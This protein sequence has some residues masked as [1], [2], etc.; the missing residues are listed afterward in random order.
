MVLRCLHAL[1]N[2]LL[3]AARKLACE[4]AGCG[5]LSADLAAD[6]RRDKDA[7]RLFVHVAIPYPRNKTNAC[8][9]NK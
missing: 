1:R 6:D 8:C 5:L 3:A 9:D 4:I 7:E 2:L